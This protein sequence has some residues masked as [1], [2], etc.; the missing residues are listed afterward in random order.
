MNNVLDI[1]RYVIKYSNEKDYDIYG[2]KITCP[3][4]FCTGKFRLKNR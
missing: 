4:L 1:A 2:L 3:T